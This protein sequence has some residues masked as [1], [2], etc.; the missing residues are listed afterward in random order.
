MGAGGGD[1][2]GMR[3]H[4]ELHTDRNLR[5]GWSTLIC[6]VL[7]MSTNDN[8]LMLGKEPNVVGT[9][10]RAISNCVTPFLFLISK[11]CVNRFSVC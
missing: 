2:G 6:S 3:E 9:H 1:G 7:L 5:S 4:A 11:F 10:T 8:F